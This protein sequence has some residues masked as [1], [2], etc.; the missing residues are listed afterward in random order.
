MKERIRISLCFIGI[1]SA[2]F[3]VYFTARVFERG[4][5]EQLRLALRESSRLVESSYKKLSSPAEL[6]QFASDSLRITLIQKDGSVLFESDEKIESMGNHKTRPEIADAF[7]KG[8]GEN[9][10]YSITLNTSVYYY[11][12]RLDDGNVLRLGMRQAN[13]QKLLSETTPYLLMLI[14][15]IIA[16]SI[17]VAILLSR[18]FVRPIQTLSEQLEDPTFL[19]DEDVNYKEMAPFIKKI[20]NQRREL[21][22]TIEQLKT[23]KSKTA[24]MKDEFT[25]NASHELKTPL[26][27]IS[28][29]AEMIETGMAR[30]EDVTS[31]ASKIHRESDRLLSIANDI[32][33][34]A[35][36][37]EPG[38][39]SPNLNENVDLR[40][41]VDAC[42]GDLS[43]SAE[44]KHVAITVV[45]ESSALSQGNNRL[46]YELFYNL[47]DNAIRYTP[48]RANVESRIEITVRKKSVT[49]KDNG[50]GIPEDS[51]GRVF[52]RF[53]RV[54][55]S[56]SKETG[57]TGLG[58]AIVKHIAELHNAKIHLESTLGV[59]TEIKVEF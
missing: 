14:V 19:D 8:V 2:I 57:G 52:E 16:A 33:T 47:I 13:L 58:L 4:M 23:E 32:M 49:V 7:N 42:V 37:D 38:D 36:L 21:E 26:T 55:K 20:R 25:A 18:L 35:K 12:V 34:L 1:L 10:R 5:D 22:L 44:K 24:R 54:D 50:I 45:G 39:T 46:L 28:G 31:F 17:L 27:S 43:L 41:I 11:A 9:L 53:Y 29:Y 48:E 3:A 6:Q 51:Q 40:E 59:G 56:R 15:V 30:P